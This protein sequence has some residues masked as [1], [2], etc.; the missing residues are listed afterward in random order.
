MRCFLALAT[1]ALAAAAQPV[2]WRN[3][4]K[5][6]AAWYGSAEAVR[7]AD[8]LLLYQHEI[9]GWG[10]NPDMALPLGPKELLTLEK[11]R[12]D[13]AAH[14]TID[15]DSTYPQMHYLARVF[16]AT[17]NERFA[18]AFR[19]GFE[20]LLKAQYPNGGWPQFNPLRHGY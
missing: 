16:T 2:P 1:F 10:Q 14:S 5:Q 13:P 6:P 12:K 19:R 20:Y 7:I 17:K 3:A 9:G 11:D 15:N 4:L 8:N 18:A